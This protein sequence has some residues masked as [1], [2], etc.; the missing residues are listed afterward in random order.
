SAIAIRP[1]ELATL[2]ALFGVGLALLSALRGLN[3]VVWIAALAFGSAAPGAIVWFLGKRR[4]RRFD[5]QLP[6]VLET[7]AA[8]LRAGH[9]L[10][11]AIQGIAA[12]TSPPAS[13]EFGRVLAEARLGRPL[14]DA[15]IAM[16]ERLGSDDLEYVASAVAVQANVGGAMA[17]LFDQA[18]ETVRHRQQHARRL[19]TLTA[20]G[21]FS[22]GTLTFLPIALAAFLTLVNPQYMLPFFEDS[23]GQIICVIGAISI[24]I[25]GLVLIRIVSIKE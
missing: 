21:R 1:I 22:A 7:I 5:T 24:L 6:V 16:C 11:Y 13:A 23:T 25:G 15:M 3:P 20:T 9:S 19:K 10:R 18:A 8:S 2:S 4:V 12:D 14:E 17:G